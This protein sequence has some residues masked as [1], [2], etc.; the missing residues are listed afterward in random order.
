MY[1]QTFILRENATF[2]DEYIR[3]TVLNNACSMK[4]RHS[5]HFSLI[6]SQSSRLMKSL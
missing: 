5:S 4:L 2:N 3:I 6:S 1:E